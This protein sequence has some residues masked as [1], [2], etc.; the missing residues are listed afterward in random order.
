MNRSFENSAIDNFVEH[1]KN[2]QIIL[3]IGMIAALRN[4]NCAMY[5]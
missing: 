3:A 5:F 1:N 4:K 2:Y